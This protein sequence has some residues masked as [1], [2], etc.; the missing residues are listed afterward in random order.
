MINELE[1]LLKQNKQ[2]SS[3]SVSQEKSLRDKLKLIIKLL[4]F[5][6]FYQIRIKSQKK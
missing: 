5:E 6:V 4:K 3:D 2:Y 1:Q